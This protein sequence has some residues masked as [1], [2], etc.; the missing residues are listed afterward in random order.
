MG[1]LVHVGTPS[2]AGVNLLYMEDW[3]EGGVASKTMSMQK[4][5]LCCQMLGGAQLWGCLT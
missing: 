5:R 3:E 1:G 4:A 2:G